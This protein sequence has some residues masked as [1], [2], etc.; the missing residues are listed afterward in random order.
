M[1]RILNPLEQAETALVKKLLAEV[2]EDRRC[3]NLRVDSEGPFC[4][5]DWNQ[6]ETIKDERRYLCDTASLQLWCLD[7]ERCEKCIYYKGEEI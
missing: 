2:E 3:P 7:I 6:G 1:V 5:K 4:A